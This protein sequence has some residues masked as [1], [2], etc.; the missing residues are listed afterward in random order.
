LSRGP[1]HYKYILLKG[2]ANSEGL[3]ASRVLMA[4]SLLSKPLKLPFIRQVVS[5]IAKL[6]SSILKIFCHDVIIRHFEVRYTINCYKNVRTNLLPNYI[7][8]LSSLKI[9]NSP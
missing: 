8:I 4:V 1:S 9:S 3:A 5:A 2:E 6:I 7:S